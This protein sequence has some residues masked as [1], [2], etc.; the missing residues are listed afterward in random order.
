[1]KTLQKKIKAPLWEEKFPRKKTQWFSATV[2]MDTR[3]ET[4]TVTATQQLDQ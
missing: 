1:M 2:V 3:R 4:L